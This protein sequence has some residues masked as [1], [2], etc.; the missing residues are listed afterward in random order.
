[1]GKFKNW[2]IHKLGG[3]TEEE[4]VQLTQ[5]QKNEKYIEQP[6]DNLNLTAE[7]ICS[8]L[9][10]L[11]VAEI[12]QILSKQITE[13]LI[14]YIEVKS[15]YIEKNHTL[16]YRATARVLTELKGATK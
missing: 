10:P 6:M 15:Q 12:K 5:F 16:R 8:Q 3:Y 9:A 7:I 1:M 13:K 14:P 11:T 4:R 2:L